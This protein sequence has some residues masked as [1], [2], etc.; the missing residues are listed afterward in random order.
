MASLSRE[1]LWEL[2]SLKFLSGG[3]ESNSWQQSYYQFL[4]KE[5]VDAEMQKRALLLQLWTTQVR[6]GFII[7]PPPHTHRHTHAHTNFTDTQPHNE[8]KTCKLSTP[9]LHA[10]I[11]CQ[12][13]IPV[14]Q[15]TQSY[16]PQLVTLS[17]TS[18]V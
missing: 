14:C 9:T 7:C 3:S 18:L 10:Q 15:V 17:D 16:L 12:E 8:T 5:G 6:A 11:P 13:W 1:Q 4:Q 2:L